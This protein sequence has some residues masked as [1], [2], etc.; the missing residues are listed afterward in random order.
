M[1]R[2]VYEESWNLRIAILERLVGTR[3]IR[4][5]VETTPECVEH[6]LQSSLAETNFLNLVVAVILFPSHDQSLSLTMSPPQVA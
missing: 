1:S 5:R 3:T 6:R 2:L 4:R